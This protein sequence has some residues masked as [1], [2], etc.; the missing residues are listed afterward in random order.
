LNS[1]LQFP[2]IPG[3]SQHK[4]SLAQEKNLNLVNKHRASRPKRQKRPTRNFKK[5]E[6][7]VDIFFEKPI[8]KNKRNS[9][10]EALPLFDNRDLVYNSSS[11]DIDTDELFS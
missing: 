7:E 1:S 8:Q 10:D 3:P 11:S 2:P 4:S 6:K 9:K 5:K